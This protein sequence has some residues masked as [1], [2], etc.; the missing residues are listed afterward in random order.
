MT[1]WEKVGGMWSESTPDNPYD[2]TGTCSLSMVS[3]FSRSKR[4]SYWHYL[5]PPQDFTTR[6]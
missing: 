3:D 4:T 2:A 6:D 1:S 5:Q